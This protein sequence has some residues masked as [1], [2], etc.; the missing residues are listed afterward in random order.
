MAGERAGRTVSKAQ[1]GD[2]EA[3]NSGEVACLPLID[4]GI[5]LCSV[6]E[7]ELLL[8]GHLA[9][10]FIDAGIAGYDRDGLRAGASHT[11][12]KRR[13]SRDQATE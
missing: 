4:R 10:Q 2:A 12:C 7:G 8:K 3:R 5:F 13:R 6:D 1:T 9:E 11:E